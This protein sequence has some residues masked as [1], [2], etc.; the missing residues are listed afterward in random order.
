MLFR[1]LIL[2]SY[3]SQPIWWLDRRPDQSP[4]HF[5]NLNSLHCER[6]SRDLFYPLARV[7]FRVASPLYQKIEP[8]NA[9]SLTVLKVFAPLPV[10]RSKQQGWDRRSCERDNR[11]VG[12]DVRIKIQLSKPQFQ[13]EQ[14]RNE[15]RKVPDAARGQQGKKPSDSL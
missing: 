9:F 8:M 3:E 15:G 2:R 4:E 13:G 1:K 10:L 5:T 12:Q 6:F 14:Q 7:G 11:T